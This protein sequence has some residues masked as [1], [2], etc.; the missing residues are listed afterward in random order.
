M[1]LS[2]RWWMLWLTLLALPLLL[3]GFLLLDPGA[4][5][6]FYNLDFHFY[7]VSGTA[8]AAAIACLIVISLTQTLRETR[9]V[10][11]GLA[12]LSIASIFAVHGLATPG[13]IY[14]ADEIYAELGISA[15]LSIFVGA[16]F[17]GLS[18]LKLPEAAEAWLKSNGVLIFS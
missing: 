9:L 13:H 2:L 14:D 1:S 4:D 15:W 18:A 3:L 5:K 7:V 10:L 11:L 12:F 8:I 17:I 6:P 16:A